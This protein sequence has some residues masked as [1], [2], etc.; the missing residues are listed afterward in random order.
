VNGRWLPLFTPC[1]M[2]L[3]FDHT[4]F[5]AGPLYHKHPS[6]GWTQIIERYNWSKDNRGQ[7]GEGLDQNRRQSGFS[8]RGAGSHLRGAGGYR[9][10]VEPPLRCKTRPGFRP[11]PDAGADRRGAVLRRRALALAAP[12]RNEKGQILRPD[13]TPI[14]RL[15]SAGELGSIYSY[16]YQGTGNIGNATAS[17]ASAHP[18]SWPK[19]MR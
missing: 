13:G 2:F 11:N 17:S 6:H 10:P 9:R 4:L 14:A 1:P 7:A 19:C 18:R 12:R 8:R 5:S 15:Y 3:I 16:P